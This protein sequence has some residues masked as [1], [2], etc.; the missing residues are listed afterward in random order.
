[1]L[2]TTSATRAP[3][4]LVYEFERRAYPVIEKCSIGR[5][6]SNDVVIPEPTVSRSHARVEMSGETLTLESSGAT[7]TRVNGRPV[8]EPRALNEG[9]RIEVGTAILTVR[10]PPLP[11]GV[12]IVDR[13]KPAPN[14]DP[15][16]ARR[17]TIRNPL[18]SGQ[19]VEKPRA[20]IGRWVIVIVVL[21]LLAAALLR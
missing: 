15:I 19:P 1:M 7:G 17:D 14:V 18:L 9:D 11:L 8:L 20:G 21:I 3:A 16:A 12:S 4:Y 2:T 13:V 6:V 5:D 10:K